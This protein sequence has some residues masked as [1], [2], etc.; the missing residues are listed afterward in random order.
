MMSNITN[1]IIF[2]SF[3]LIFLIIIELINFY[4]FLF[5]S[6]INI[7]LLSTTCHIKR[8]QFFCEII[9]LR[10]LLIIYLG[11]NNK[12]P[13]FLKIIS[14][15]SLFKKFLAIYRTLETQIFWN[16]SLRNSIIIKM[17]RLAHEFSAIKT[18]R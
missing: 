3:F 4:W 11:K 13:L 14:T 10:R 5:G 17:P 1:T 9:C 7:I 15:L 16:S 18:R 6:T 2:H 8:R 12:I